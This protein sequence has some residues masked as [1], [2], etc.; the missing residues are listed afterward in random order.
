MRKAPLSAPP[1]VP[2]SCQRGRSAVSVAQVGAGG[3]RPRPS[4]PPWQRRQPR[5]RGRHHRVTADLPVS[6]CE[7]T[8]HRQPMSRHW[9][10]RPA[11]NSQ[12]LPRRRRRSWASEAS[13]GAGETHRRLFRTGVTLPAGVSPERGIGGHV[14][15]LGVVPC[16]HLATVG[17]G[18]AAPTTGAT[19]SHGPALSR[20][21][22]ARREG[23]RRGSNSRTRAPAQA[24]HRRITK[25]PGLGRGRAPPPGPATA[26]REATT[27]G[28]CQ[29]QCGSSRGRQC[30]GRRAPLEWSTCRLL[31]LN[32]PGWPAALLQR[33]AAPGR[34]HGHFHGEGAVEPAGPSCEHT[35]ADNGRRLPRRRYDHPLPPPST[36]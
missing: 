30:F 14:V 1:V 3:R 2:N 13:A 25:S 35:L 12:P 23:T 28:R 21:S 4:M 9:S 34:S 22:P 8:S 11:I 7:R 31:A 26:A 17:D 27:C 18:A 5:Q 33:T 15:G 24:L 6:T 16:S 29:R 10:C 19:A 32:A 20:P 36:G